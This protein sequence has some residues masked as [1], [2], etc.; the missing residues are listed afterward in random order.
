MQMLARCFEKGVR[1]SITRELQEGKSTLLGT[2]LKAFS[3]QT[4]EWY[5][6]KMK[7]ENR[8]WL[9]DMI[10]EVDTESRNARLLCP[11]SFRLRRREFASFMEPTRGVADVQ[12]RKRILREIILQ[13]RDMVPKFE[14]CN[15]VPTGL[16]AF[17]TNIMFAERL[18]ELSGL[19]E[20]ERLGIFSSHAIVNYE[21]EMRTWRL[22]IET[23][24]SP[25]TIADTMQVRYRTCTNLTLVLSKEPLAKQL[26]E[27]EDVLAHA[28]GLK[29]KTVG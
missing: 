20:A 4:R 3:W 11:S 9:P 13:L 29:A 27:W 19:L 7:S 8:F 14:T 26:P 25:F 22:P 18:K 17:S 24:F 16:Y 6:E 12:E 21:V 10:A 23:I 2:G 5:F 15:G 1:N 28:R